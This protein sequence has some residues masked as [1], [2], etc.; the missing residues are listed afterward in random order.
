MLRQ[1]VFGLLLCTAAVAHSAEV[2]PSTVTRFD[3]KCIAGTSFAWLKNTTTFED[4]CTACAQATE[5]KCVAFDIVASRGCVLK[6]TAERMYEK[7]CTV[8]GS[9]A[10]ISPSPT[11]PSPGPT[12]PKPAEVTFSDMFK[13]WNGAVPVLQRSVTVSV[14][15][16]APAQTKLTLSLDGKRVASALTNSSG[17]WMAYIPPQ[18]AGYNRTMT[19]GAVDTALSATTVVS[20][21]ETI[22]CVGQSNMGMQVGPSVRGFDADNATA[23]NAASVRYTGRISLHSRDSRWTDAK[24]VSPNSTVWYAVD[25]ITIK[26]F[27]AV[28]WLSGRI[29]FDSL[30]PQG[31]KAQE[32]PVGLAM[33]AIGAHPVESWL[34]PDQLAAC[35]ITTPCS[36]H[37]PMSKIWASTIIPMQPFTFGTMLYDQAE[38]D[39]ICSREAQYPCMQEQLAS[40]YRAQFNV[41]FPFIA[42]QLPGYTEDAFSMRLAQDAAALKTPNAAVIATYDDSCAEDNLH[43]CPH[44]NVHNVHK[45]PVGTRVAAMI[46]KLT[47]KEDLVAEG[48]RVQTITRGAGDTVLLKFSGGTPPFYFAPT[49]NCTTCCD[50]ESDFDVSGDGGKTW[51]NGTAAAV[52]KDVDPTGATVRFSVAAAH[53]AAAQS[54]RV[55]YTAN[56]VFPQCALYNKE[57]LP[58]MPFD[59]TS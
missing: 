57:A 26:N 50:A 35:G 47:L 32:V 11:P 29:L 17:I 23:E 22:L 45:L 24:G 56:R 44:G 39:I 36:D 53:F 25:P 28:C 19:V 51:V 31:S 54:L 43:G 14:W 42:V 34:G 58:A 15:G 46:R 37:M 49:R 18:S 12:P 6:S 21:G 52:A 55:R 20:F 3:N 40:S 27:S 7:D 8:A 1:P 9:T 33:N 4:C 2:C 5:K 59:K 10:P 13:G 41:S 38:A 30:N 48:P 16:T